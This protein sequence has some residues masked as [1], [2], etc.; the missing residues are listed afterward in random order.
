MPGDR[1]EQLADEAVRRMGDDADAA[2]G[3]ATRISSSAVSTWSGANIAP[4]TEVTTSKLRVGEGQRL[5]VR[6]DVVRLEALGPRPPPGRGR[7]GPGT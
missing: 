3:R 7:A 2:T 1:P 5:C 6:L 4:N